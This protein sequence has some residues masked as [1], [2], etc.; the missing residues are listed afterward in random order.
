MTR[1]CTETWAS[2]GPC[3][4]PKGDVSVAGEEGG[5]MDWQPIETAP[6]DR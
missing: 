4:Y 6:K 2:M 1:S 3:S 5:M